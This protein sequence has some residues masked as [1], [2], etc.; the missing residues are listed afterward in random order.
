MN[1]GGVL[2]LLATL[3]ALLVA[4]GC[5][6]SGSDEVT[7]QTGSLSKATFIK[8]ADAICEAARSEF[9]A[10]LQRFLKDHQKILVS[11]DVEAKKA[12]LPEILESL[13]QPNIEGQ[14][15]QISTLGAPKGYAPEVAAFLNA[16]QS[17]MNKALENPPGF[18]T[19]PTPFVV[20]ENIARRATLKGCSES[21]S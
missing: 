6:S 15:E 8:K 1:R 3:A 16:L 21:F 20:A 17:R 11:G 13:L 5:G 9:L 2:S 19:T 12:L 7:V 4:A 18:S 14:V 10:K